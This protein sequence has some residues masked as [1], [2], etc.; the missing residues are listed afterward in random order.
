MGH[1]INLYFSS[2]NIGKN[3]RIT[4]V[5]ILIKY[6]GWNTVV[7][8]CIYLTLKAFTDTWYFNL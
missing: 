7:L 6:V 3:F 1:N 5:F 4:L 8:P 2:K